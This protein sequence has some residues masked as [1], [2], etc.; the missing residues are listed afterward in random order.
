M[1]FYICEHCKNIIYFMNE[2]N[3]KFSC[4]GEN[5]TL[6]TASSSDGALEKHVP[7]IKQNGNNVVVEIGQ[8][9]HPM[10]D[11][12]YIEWIALETKKRR[13]I[14]NL[15]PNDEPKASFTIENDDEIVAAY[16]YCNIHGLYQ[17]SSL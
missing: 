7:V 5:M 8:I 11:V 15:K 9:P 17:K 14:Q 12:H 6:I 4:C 16:E 1:K 3:S 10:L 2:N 13:Y